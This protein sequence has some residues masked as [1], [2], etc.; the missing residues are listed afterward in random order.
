M[1][2]KCGKPK[3]PYVEKGIISP[4][5]EL[6]KCSYALKE[7]FTMALKFWGSPEDK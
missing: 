3:D 1:K 4:L 7:D 5:P 2:I 6:I